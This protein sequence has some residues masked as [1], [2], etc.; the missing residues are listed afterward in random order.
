MLPQKQN[1][2]ATDRDE[3]VIVAAHSTRIAVRNNPPFQ[4]NVVF[5]PNLRRSETKRSFARS[6]SNVAR[7]ASAKTKT[8]TKCDG[9]GGSLRHTMSVIRYKCESRR[10]CST[11]RS[12]SSNTV[13]RGSRRFVWCGRGR[14][15]LMRLS[16]LNARRR[17]R[18]K[19]TERTLRACVGCNLAL[20]S[21]APDRLIASGS[22]EV[23][24]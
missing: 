5:A 12:H 9:E 14:W 13:R 19:Q 10:C 7:C 15:Q 16:G 8:K 3:A 2:K 24:A 6:L 22:E 1:Q 20:E 11:R 21:I 4:R 17:D 18:N 23:E